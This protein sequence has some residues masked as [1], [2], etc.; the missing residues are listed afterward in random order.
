V[1]PP[2]GG[3]VCTHI[4]GLRTTFHSPGGGRSIARSPVVDAHGLRRASTRKSAV[5]YAA[6]RTLQTAIGAGRGGAAKFVVHASILFFLPRVE[7]A[8][9]G[10]AC[11]GVLS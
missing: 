5:P 6:R 2:A 4:F 8:T 9:D 1:T 3:N 11:C 7:M 10:N